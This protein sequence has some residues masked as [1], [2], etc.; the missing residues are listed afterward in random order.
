MDRTY[1]LTLRMTDVRANE[2]VR[3]T[4]AERISLVWPLTREVVSLSKNP[5]PDN[6]RGVL[7]ALLR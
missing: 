6:A 7:R 3:G 2:I 1:T 5:S 4:P